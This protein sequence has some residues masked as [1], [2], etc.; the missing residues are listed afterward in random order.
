[1]RTDVRERNRLCASGQLA[2]LLQFEPRIF[3]V[4]P[5]LEYLVS[6]TPI[7]T[8]ENEVWI[9]PKSRAKHH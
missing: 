3:L 4:D 2:R 5:Y 6:S 9:E 7:V 8:N 1:M